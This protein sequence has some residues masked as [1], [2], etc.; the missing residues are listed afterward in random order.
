MHETGQLMLSFPQEPENGVDAKETDKLLADAN[1]SV[2]S[3]YSS[4]S[5]W[6]LYGLIAALAGSY[7]LYLGLSGGHRAFLMPCIFLLSRLTLQT[8]HFFGNDCC[9]SSLVQVN[10]CGI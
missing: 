9:S 7:A 2:V 6:L 3:M 4:V 10:R 5:A 8:V 1:A